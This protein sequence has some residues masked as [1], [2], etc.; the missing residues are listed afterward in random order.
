MEFGPV[1]ASARILLAK[2]G[3][4]HGVRG[5]VRVKAFTGDP[6]ALGRYGPLWAEDGRLF[7]IERLRPA[8]EVVVAKFRGIDDRN[9]AEALNGTP[10]Y[11]DRE[12]LPDPEEDEY[13]HADLIGLAAE[14]SAGERLGTVV[15]IHDFGAG[16]IVE[17][18]PPEGP[19]LLVPFTKETVPA[20]DL[21]AARI[22]IELPEETEAREGEEDA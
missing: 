2:I 19:S 1:N 15:A 11:V 10:L 18:A 3:T 20:V 16:D 4:A 21:A 5:E 12:R 7:E 17:I 22:V 14:T 8:K 9:A 13:Y 6:A